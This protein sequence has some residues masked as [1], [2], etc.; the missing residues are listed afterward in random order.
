[1]RNILVIILCIIVSVSC[2]QR[3]IYDQYKDA[4]DA[5]WHK[6]SL[7]LFNIPEL[8]SLQRYNLFITLRNNND[9]AYQNLFLIANMKFPNGKTTIDTLEYEMA[10]PDGSWLGTGFSDLKENVLWYKEGVRFSE[11]GSYS[12]SLEH[13]M[14]KNGVIQGEEVLSGIIDVGFRIEKAEN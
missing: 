10:R 14:R 13:A 2:D 9:Y 12:V 1:M 7:K 11:I 8:D 4:S 6:D 5:G 3:R